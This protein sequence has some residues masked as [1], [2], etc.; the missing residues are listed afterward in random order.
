MKTMDSN[1]FVL[2]ACVFMS[3][4]WLFLFCSVGSYTTENFS[5]F[6]DISYESLWYKF[7]KDLKKYL[8]LIIADAQQPRIFS[9]LGITSLDMMTFT[10]VLCCLRKRYPFNL[11]IL[12][13]D[14]AG[15]ENCEQLLF[16]VQK[17]NGQIGRTRNL[18]VFHFYS[19][20]LFILS[21]YQQNS[22]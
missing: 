13:F 18:F 12:I 14:Y 1:I 21:T 16:D 15:D 10:Q 17:F 8:Q 22:D 11:N 7:P 20:T 9:G 19:C 3:A 6:A 2:L 5:L 4:G